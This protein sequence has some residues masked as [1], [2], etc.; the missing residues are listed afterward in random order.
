[1]AFRP[2]HV[3][4]PI[5]RTPPSSACEAVTHITRRQVTSSR[6]SGT[7]A[8]SLELY[9]VPAW[10]RGYFGINAAGHVVVRPDGEDG[11]AGRDIDLYEVVQGLEARDL[12]APVVIRFSD[13]LRNGPVRL[14]A[15]FAQAIA[16][17]D[18]RNRYIAVFPVKVNQQQ[19]GRA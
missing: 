11:A 18:Y 12:T 19:I 14:R 17:N 3:M 4:S 6:A 15:A 9:Q 5:S 16:E 13:I 10:G 2:H 7:I 1:S 8:A